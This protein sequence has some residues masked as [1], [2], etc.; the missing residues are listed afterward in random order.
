MDRSSLLEILEPYLRK[1]KEEEKKKKEKQN[2]DERTLSAVLVLIH[3]QQG[4]PHV[5]LTKRSAKLKSH[6]GQISFPGGTLSD[7]DEGLMQTAIRETMEEIGVRMSEDEIA[8]SLPSA[9]TMTSS[10]MIVPYVAV[11]EQ[12]GRLAPNAEEIDAILDLSLLDLLRTI[13][14]DRDRSRYGEVYRFEYDGNLVWGATARILKQI[15]DIL[16]ERGMI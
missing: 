8:G 13:T 1:D 15:Y 3:F 6:A 10:F 12:L 11:V 16:H 4:D 9:K 5:I 7:S 2:S 14:I